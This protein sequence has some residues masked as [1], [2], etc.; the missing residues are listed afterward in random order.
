VGVV[1]AELGGGGAG[2]QSA[3]RFAESLVGRMAA[4][5]GLYWQRTMATQLGRS[6]ATNIGA[7]LGMSLWA[8]FLGGSA[9]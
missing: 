4:T 9:K 7:D 1:A 8:R 3:G 2:D 6:A 5:F